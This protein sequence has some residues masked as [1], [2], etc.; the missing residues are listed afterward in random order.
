M[1]SHVMYIILC[2]RYE[3]DDG[4]LHKEEGRLVDGVWVI[5]SEFSCSSDDSPIQSFSFVG[6]KCGFNSRDT[7][8]LGLNEKLGNSIYSRLIL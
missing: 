3:M 1:C 7:T 8:R 4:T 2:R 5:A 6:N